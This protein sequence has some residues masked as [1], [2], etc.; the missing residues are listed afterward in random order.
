MTTRQSFS[1][2]LATCA[3][4]ISNVNLALLPSSSHPG[5]VGRV[6]AGSTRGVD[7]HTTHTDV[8]IAAR[9]SSR[10]SGSI[11]SDFDVGKLKPYLN[12]E[13]GLSPVRYR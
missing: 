9:I 1:L 6:V 2:L 13:D 10:R 3:H 7:V 11:K 8:P 5:L 4:I 12:E